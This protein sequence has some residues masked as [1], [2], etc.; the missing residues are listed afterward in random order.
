MKYPAFAFSLVAL[1]ALACGLL[2]SAPQTAPA[3]EPAA[4]PQE[5]TA[6][7]PEAIPTS[8]LPP[9]TGLPYNFEHFSFTI[10]DGMAGGATGQSLPPLTGDDN[11]PPWEVTPGHLE[12][13]LDGYALTEKFHFPR[14]YVFPVVGLAA[15]QPG[16]AENISRLQEILAGPDAPLSIHDLPGI[17]FFNAGTVF[18]SNAQ[19]IHFQ[20]GSG[21]RALAVFGQYYAPVNNH[22]LFY[23]FQGLTDNGQYYIIV[24]LPITHPGLQPDSNPGSMPADAGFPAYPDYTTATDVEMGNYYSNM[25]DLLNNARP[26]IFAPNLAHLDR[27]MESIQITP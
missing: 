14:L 18:A 27:M 1:A 24:I 26:E 19:V 20:N 25:T 15:V 21:V 11:M 2:T 13:R 7:Q 23:H 4:P 3:M 12:I 16:A 17:H 22:D 6:P 9:Q 8:T 5:E 10:P